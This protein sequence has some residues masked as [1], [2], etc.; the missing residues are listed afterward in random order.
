MPMVN[1]GEFA[2]FCISFIYWG[3]CSIYVCILVSTTNI[4]LCLLIC[5]Y[6]YSTKSV[7]LYYNEFNVMNLIY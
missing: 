7:S 6:M 5:M 3:Q 4:W 2:L 1:H